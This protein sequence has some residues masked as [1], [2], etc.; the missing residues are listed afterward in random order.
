[1]SCLDDHRRSLSYTGFQAPLRYAAY[2]S[3]LGTGNGFLGNPAD[4]VRIA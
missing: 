4:S 1:M 2:N 3:A